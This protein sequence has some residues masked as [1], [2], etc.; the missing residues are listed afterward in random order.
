MNQWGKEVYANSPD[1]EVVFNYEFLEDYLDKH[2]SDNEDPPDQGNR[3]TETYRLYLEFN[4][5]FLLLFSSSINLWRP[6]KFTKYNYPLYLIV[7][8]NCARNPVFDFAVMLR[9]SLGFHINFPE[10]IW[11]LKASEAPA[12]DQPP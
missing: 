1:F 2:S 3:Y 12:S 8:L 5:Y 10:E 9:L 11:L 6:K 7:S 4:S